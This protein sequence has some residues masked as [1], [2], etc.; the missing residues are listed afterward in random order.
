MYSIT[1]TSYGFTLKNGLKNNAICS[2]IATTKNAYKTNKTNKNWHL[3]HKQLQA[4]T[5]QTGSLLLLCSAPC[6]VTAL[7][8]ASCCNVA[9]VFYSSYFIVSAVTLTVGKRT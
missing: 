4:H 9:K 6:P 7:S 8:F 5:Q 1:A 3:N 2:N